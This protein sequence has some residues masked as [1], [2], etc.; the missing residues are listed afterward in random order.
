M[1]RVI[2]DVPEL[3]EMLGS[4]SLDSSIGGLGIEPGAFLLGL[5]TTE[6]QVKRI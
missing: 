4:C 1:L 5:M 6:L 2:R 3:S